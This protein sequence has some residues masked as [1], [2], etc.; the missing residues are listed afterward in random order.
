MIWALL[1]LAQPL[2]MAPVLIYTSSALDEYSYLARAR[3]R[4]CATYGLANALASLSAD[5]GHGGFWFYSGADCG[6]ATH[7]TGTGDTRHVVSIGYAPSAASPI[8]VSRLVADVEGANSGGKWLWHVHGG[9]RHL[10]GARDFRLTTNR[11]GL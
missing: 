8:A 10:E 2:I 1:L 9:R 11:G 4:A 3:A 7:V 5:H 6:V